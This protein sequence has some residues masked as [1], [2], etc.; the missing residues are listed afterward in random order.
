MDWLVNKI[1]PP[2]S[3][4]LIKALDKQ[5]QLTKPLGSLGLLEE[6]AVRLAAM[7]KTENPSI[8]QIW[9]SIFAADHGISEESVSAFPQIVTTEMVKNFVNSGAA[10]N[11]L[12]RYIKADFEVIDVG[13]IAA[14]D[15]EGVISER[16]GN[17]TENFAKQAAMTTGQ[18]Q[19]ALATGKAAVER[20]V[21]HRAH[22]FIGGEMG[23][24]N[25]TSASAI[26]VVLT[27]MTVE[28]LTGTGTG[29]DSRAV[30]HKA[31]VIKRAISLHQNF[32]INPLNVLQYLGGFEIAALVGAYV[33]SAQRGLPIVVD[34]FISTT[35][36]L[37][38]VKINP[39]IQSWLIYAHCSE[40]KGHKFILDY[41]DARPLLYLNMR[42]G[43]GSGAVTA[44][45]LIQMAC[46]LQSEMAT[47]QQA[48]ITTKKEKG[49]K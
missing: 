14:I 38:A 8:N 29:I 5:Q 43:E 15:V 48:K 10:I 32:L 23:I 35:A 16:A 11:V 34:G 28:Q 49:N 47:F 21:N 6:I 18:M 27:G 4:F 20:A 24:A 40:E 7:Q 30:E 45:P 17:G 42:L 12:S 26:A 22:L 44:V 37:L 3:A 25:T 13:L 41:L 33:F 46:K 19:S 31:N 1:E 9:V 39:E 2:D 36:A